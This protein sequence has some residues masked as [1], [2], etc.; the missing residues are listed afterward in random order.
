MKKELQSTQFNIKRFAI[1]I[2]SSPGLSH[3]SQSTTVIWS[4]FI[5]QSCKRGKRIQDWE[6]YGMAHKS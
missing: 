5:F 3:D 6:T 2:W 4:W 1:N